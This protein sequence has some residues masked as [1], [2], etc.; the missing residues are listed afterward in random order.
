[1][2]ERKGGWVGQSNRGTG[3]KVAGGGRKGGRKRGRVGMERGK[4]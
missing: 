1:M 2:H 3:G 4:F